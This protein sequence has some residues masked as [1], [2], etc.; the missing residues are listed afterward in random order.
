MRWFGLIIALAGGVL[1]FF[2]GPA[3]WLQHSLNQTAKQVEGTVT[4]SR[5]QEYRGRKNRKRYRAEIAYQYEVNGVTYA[6]RRINAAD[7]DVKGSTRATSVVARFPAGSQVPVFVSPGS[8]ERGFL[9]KEWRHEPYTFLI[10]GLSAIAVGAGMFLLASRVREPAPVAGAT[11]PLWELSPGVSLL[12]KW[13]TLLVGGGVWLAT[14]AGVGG[15]YVAM[16]AWQQVD[17]AFYIFAGFCVTCAVVAVGVGAWV[18]WVS[19]AFADARVMLDSPRPVRGKKL[20]VVV[21]QP[22][23]SGSPVDA[24]DVS[25]VCTETIVTG[26]GKS[27]SVKKREAWSE[28]H[29]PLQAGGVMADG[30]GV[31][32]GVVTFD[33]P[34]STM[35][36]SAKSQVDHRFDWALRLRTHAA[37]PDYKAVW[38]VTVE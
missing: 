5:V 35:P 30:D 19:R 29:S 10:I 17:V 22:V 32:R 33:L 6:S 37:G 18:F 24:M 21:E 7:Y 9:V 23:R 31:V 28:L 11:P 12:T 26:A 36:T 15:H 8:E 20:L 2:M 1:A 34:V 25:L 14:L 27:R 38:P 4:E 3:V 16:V 13:M